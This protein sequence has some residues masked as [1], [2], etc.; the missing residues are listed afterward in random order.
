MKIL[1]GLVPFFVALPIVVASAIWQG[2]KTERWGKFPE[3]DVCAARINKIPLEIGGGEWKGT[4]GPKM[5]ENIRK[6][7]G[8]VGDAQILYTNSNGQKVNLLVVCGRLMDVWNH[9]PDRCY[10]AHGYKQETDPK[11]TQK[12]TDDEKAPCDFLSSIY[13]LQTD[14]RRV[15]VYWGWSSDGKWVAPDDLRQDFFRTDPI[16]KI[17]VETGVAEDNEP[18]ERG[19]GADFIKVL[20]P[21]LNRVLFPGYKPPAQVAQAA[22]A[23]K[24]LTAAPAASKPDAAKPEAA[25]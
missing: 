14:Q 12:L 9:R 18:A 22:S 3:L 23:A 21:E 8:A 1:F 7:A 20:L 19:P 15:R 24:D 17:Q 2:G 5:D 4:I 6:Y 25:K 13:T 10:P 11:G 16:F